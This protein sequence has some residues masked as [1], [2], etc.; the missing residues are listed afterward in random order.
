M[1]KTF[2][3]V[4]LFGVCYFFCFLSLL[5]C[6]AG[7]YIFPSVNAAALA[8]ERY[9]R[10]EIFHQLYPPEEKKTVSG[11]EKKFNGQKFVYIDPGSFITGCSSGS[12]RIEISRGFWLGKYEV[13]CSLWYD[14]G[15]NQSICGK[16]MD[17]TI[18]NV[19]W[20]DVEFF[21][22]KLNKK[23]C[24][25][26][27]DSEQVW[28]KKAE[29]CYRLPTDAEWEYVASAGYDNDH[30]LNEKMNSHNVSNKF[31]VFDMYGGVSEYV[32]DSYGNNFSVCG[33]GD[34]VDPINL[35]ND[36]NRVIRGEELLTSHD[37]LSAS[38]RKTVRSDYVDV[39]VGFRL[40]K[41]LSGN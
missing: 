38:T 18:S 25:R 4:R 20:S 3:F 22:K 37:F 6:S 11:K 36:E 29:G 9:E 33:A 14:F 17:D 23:S 21:I 16:G 41:V 1:N 24:G 39:K 31:G 26:E 40:L 19:S 8:V 12:C 15:G 28:Q 32:L 7:D 2:F 35:T 30:Q 5:V 27:F 13:K 10:V 34:C